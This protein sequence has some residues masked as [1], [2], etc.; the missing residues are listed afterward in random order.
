[1]DVINTLCLSPHILPAWCTVF[2]SFLIPWSNAQ[3]LMF[4]CCNRRGARGR[5]DI[6]ENP[7]RSMI[8]CPAASSFTLSLVRDLQISK[9]LGLFLSLMACGIRCCPCFSEAAVLAEAGWLLLSVTDGSGVTD[10]TLGALRDPPVSWCCSGA[11]SR[12]GKVYLKVGNEEE[13]QHQRRQGMCKRK[14]LF[15]GKI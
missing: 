8:F 14:T 13:E 15:W 1:M 3:E 10:A 11:D 7:S 2:H 6:A 9:G 5:M 12:W 4:C